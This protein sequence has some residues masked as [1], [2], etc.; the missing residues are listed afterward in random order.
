M[1]KYSTYISS[2]MQNLR[3]EF[4]FLVSG[5][6]NLLE[7]IWINNIKIFSFGWNLSPMLIWIRFNS[8]EHFF[9]FRLEVACLRKLGLKSLSWDLVSRLIRICKTPWWFS[10][11]LLKTE[12]RFFAK[13]SYKD[14]IVSFSW[15]LVLRLIQTCRI[16]FVMF[17]VFVFDQ[18]N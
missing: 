1:L 15:N 10:L 16:H 2:N 18:K 3:V 13:L 4:T 14:Q 6:K 5:W 11:F 9:R 17:N 8:D 7:Q 12:I